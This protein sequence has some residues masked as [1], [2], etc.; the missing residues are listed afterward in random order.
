MEHP[1]PSAESARFVDPPDGPPVDRP[2]DRR[3][4]LR[5]AA[6]GAMLGMLPLLASSGVAQA[7]AVSSGSTERRHGP[8]S[9]PSQRSGPVSQA[10]GPLPLLGGEEFPIGL[11][12]PPPPF[13]TTPER[14]AEIRQAGFTFVITGNYLADS[15]ILRRVCEVAEQIGLK[16]LVASDPDVGNLARN[17]TITDDRSVPLS[18]TPA[19]A[20]T[21]AQRALGHYQGFDSFAGF[22]L[23]DEPSAPAFASLSKAYEAVREVAPRVL[24][25]SNLFP[26]N[27]DGYRDYVRAYVDTV[28]P[29]VLSFDRYPIL[30]NGEDQNYFDN[31][32]II[33]REGLRANLPT[34]VYI[35]S[36][37][38]ANHRF[39]N[40][41]E[42]RW[43]IAISLAYG[44]KGIQ[45]F[46]WWQPDPARGEAF[47]PAIIDL[48]GERTA[49]YEASKKINT[50]WLQPIGR[51]LKPLTSESVQHANE[52]PLPPGT[53]GF[54][55]DSHLTAV[56]G[57]AV[58]IG[59]FTEAGNS[60][61]KYVFVANRLPGKPAK[62]TLTVDPSVV[63]EIALY[64]PAKD[65]YV[66]QRD[67]RRVRV[68]LEAGSAKLYR[69]DG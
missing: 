40:E 30:T 17:F 7:G 31:W 60:A 57:D 56:S 62:A 32:A 3:G 45:Y 58:V 61:R 27:G 34:W 41:A 52:D 47:G 1:R 69:L 43:Q 35:Q 59:R 53:E 24:P 49:L 39:P 33:R 5:G 66:P 22:N 42:V 64:D 63:K 48:E 20:R 68:S 10:C 51:R 29:S 67:P 16:V 13:E 26:G 46:T 11:F 9:E 8:Q 15:H 65:E 54:A 55:S 38:Y 19:D 4:I 2:V 36:V 23:Y 21:L 6:T 18:I 14:Y 25:Y 44:A 37:Q 12:W 28:K 50:A